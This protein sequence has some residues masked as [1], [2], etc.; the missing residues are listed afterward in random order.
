MQL[1][2]MEFYAKGLLIL[3]MGFFCNLSVAAGFEPV[4]NIKNIAKDFV[5]KNITLEEGET[6]ELQISKSD[7]PSKLAACSS[8]ITA[9]FPKETNKERISAVELTCNGDNSWH[10][11]VPVNAQVF[12]KVL[13][14][15]QTLMAN[16][17]ITEADLEY[18]QY[19]INHLYSGYFKD[20]NE[21]LG[22]VAAQTINAGVVL[23]K[24]NIH[25]RKLVLKNQSIDLIARSNTL[26]VT[27]KGIAKTDGGLNDTITA[28]N[29]SSKKMLDAV[30]VGLN[31]AEVMS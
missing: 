30:V 22:Q 18:S 16:E 25:G 1:K 28:Y 12:A 20:K 5:T 17:P 23:N 24:K 19:D 14:A 29:P 3:S 27:M 8:E 7:L 9:A 6:L 21:V 11:F 4:E 26:E 10:V 2:K 15:K 31:R 13:V